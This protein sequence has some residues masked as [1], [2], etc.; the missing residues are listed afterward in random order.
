[1]NSCFIQKLVKELSTVALR[2]PLEFNQQSELMRGSNLGPN[3][4]SLYFMNCYDYMV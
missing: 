2:N 3:D 1:M 4:F